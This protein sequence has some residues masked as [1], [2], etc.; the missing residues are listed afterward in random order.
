MIVA[1]FS[2][3]ALKINVPENFSDF[4]VMN[5]KTSKEIAYEKFIKEISSFDIVLLGESHK[6][7]YHHFLEQKIVLD[8]AKF[9]PVSAVF[10][11]G[12]SDMQPIWDKAKQNRNLISEDDLKSAI[13]WDKSW[14]WR[15][16]GIV[17]TPIF[18]SDVNLVAGNLTKGEISTIY[19]GAMPLKG[20]ISV[21]K[22]VKNRI[23]EHIKDTHKISDD[24]ILD[25]MVQ[26]QQ[27]KDR[28]MADKLIQGSNQENIAVLI[29]GRFH[30]DKILGV[31][32]HLFDFDKDKKVVVVAFGDQNEILND[33]VNKRFDYLIEFTKGVK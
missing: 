23:K 16:Y 33:E 6:R 3:C 11:M 10:E 26:I 9:K 15:Y 4:R 20:K 13:S 27:Y 31:P 21:E 18:Y 25:K 17:V 5:A 2:G 28:R 32:L 1:L 22:A 19:V 14:D 7:A 24:E 12:A 29:A 30:T 8:L